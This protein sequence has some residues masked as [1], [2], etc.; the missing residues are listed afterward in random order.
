MTYDPKSVHYESALEDFHD[1]RRKA[2][3]QAIL[4]RLTGKSYAMLPYD[5][6]RTRLGGIE[7]PFRELKD[8]PLDTIVGTVSRYNDFSRT[9][10]PLQVTDGTRWARVRI[11]NDEMEG[12][13]PI[14]VYQIGDAYFILDGHHRASVARELGNQFIQ[15]YVRQV[16]TRVPL[17]PTDEIEDIILKAEYTTFLKQTHLDELR[18][19]VDLRVTVP[20]EYDT[21]LEHISV[22]RYFMGINEKREIPYEE[23]VIHWFD[24]LYLP[25]ARIIHQRNI[26]KDFPKRTE[27]D[28]YIWV[29]EHRAALESELGWK[30]NPEIAVNDI[31]VRFTPNIKQV[32]NRILQRIINTITPEEFEPSI[33]PGTW[34]R[35][36]VDEIA[37]AGL[38]PNIL[39]AVPGDEPGWQALDI[40]IHFAT[41]EK[42]LIGGLHITSST[43]DQS[44]VEFTA[45]HDRFIQHFSESNVEGMLAIERGDVTR[46]IYDRSHWADLLVLRLLFPPPL[47]IFRR[48]RSGLRTLIR[49]SP[50]PLLIYPPGASTQ[51]H[52][53]VLAYG[54]GLRA[55]EALFVATYLA[56]RWDVKL[57]VITVDR[58]RSGDDL[59]QNKAREYL[60]SHDVHDVDYVK[61]AGDPARSIILSRELCDCDL[62]IMG[63][64]ESGLLREILFGS[65]VDRVLASVKSSV[66]ICQ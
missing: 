46:V 21:L 57:T 4:S 31:K 66:L 16:R 24:M 45:L 62:I 12:L 41:H 11:A 48:L 38:F 40:A 53:A 29:M 30:V 19:D 18:P 43:T 6:V 26:L 34:R 51:I 14:E 33:P 54:G 28:L 52:S 1:A 17:F 59:L 27:T 7:L 10:L 55:D 50:A 65:T 2:S 25:V 60:E 61:S 23:A 5:E 3:L 32:F 39:V 58:D 42:S 63:G 49:L 13:P 56:S 37:E 22:H 64:Y 8:I 15:A 47:Q 44:A 9:L 36:R 20:G 35:Q